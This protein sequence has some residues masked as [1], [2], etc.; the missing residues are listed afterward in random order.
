MSPTDSQKSGAGAVRDE[1]RVS[2]EMGRAAL[3][4]VLASR[5]F[6]SAKTLSRLL[7][8]LVERTLDGHAEP[9]KEYSLGVDV[10]GRPADFDPRIDSIVRVETSRLPPGRVLPQRGT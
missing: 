8:Y 3:E 6:L 4:Q 9:L 5:H 2:P 10:L 1:V 7:R